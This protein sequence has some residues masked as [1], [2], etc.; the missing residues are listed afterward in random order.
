M[1]KLPIHTEY[2]TL[3]VGK[4]VDDRPI[5]EV[6]NMETGV[7]EY[8]DF[9]LPRSIEAL[10]NLNTRLTEAYLELSAETAPLSLVAK[11]D[12]DEKGSLH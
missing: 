9:I 8:D 12:K 1:R 2:Y 3:G 10:H 4:S 11:G 7:V 6:V 5:Y